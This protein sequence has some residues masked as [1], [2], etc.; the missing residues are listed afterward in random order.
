MPLKYY[1]NYLK[2]IAKTPNES[3][4]EQ[5]QQTITSQFDD[6]TLLEYNVKQETEARDFTFEQI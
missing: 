5:Q 2:N 1:N 6:T 4:R 3:W